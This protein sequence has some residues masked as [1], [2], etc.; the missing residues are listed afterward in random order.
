MNLY[1]RCVPNNRSSGILEVNSRPEDLVNSNGN[2]IKA[3][4]DGDRLAAKVRW[5]IK[6]GL[7]PG[8]LL[9]DLDGDNS[10]DQAVQEWMDLPW[11]PTWEDQTWVQDP[12]I[13][14]GVMEMGETTGARVPTMEDL[15][16]VV[17][18]QTVVLLEGLEDLM[19]LQTEEAY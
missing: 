17:L 11:P 14:V 10:G 4:E 13:I 2:S 1:S 9:L 3:Q 18:D 15:G 5:E 6:E 12:R 19:S 7:A 8:D 16:T